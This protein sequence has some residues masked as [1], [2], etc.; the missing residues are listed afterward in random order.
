MNGDNISLKKFRQYQTMTSL[1][2][3]CK[4]TVQNKNQ[5]KNVAT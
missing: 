3:R 5:I 2:I 4:A 1:A